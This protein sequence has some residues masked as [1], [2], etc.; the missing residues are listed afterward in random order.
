MDSDKVIVMD[1]GTIIEFA[2]PHA[3]LKNPE[4]HFS[5]MVEQT[6]PTMTRQLHDIAETSYRNKFGKKEVEDTRL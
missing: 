3:L 1:A 6:G 5:K 4:G 2:H